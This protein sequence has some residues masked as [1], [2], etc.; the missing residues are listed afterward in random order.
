MDKIEP[1]A[2]SQPVSPGGQA[3]RLLVYETMQAHER[4]AAAGNP[5]AHPLWSALQRFAKNPESILA[6]K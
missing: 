5:E 4:L 6:M 1:K 3:V 2:V